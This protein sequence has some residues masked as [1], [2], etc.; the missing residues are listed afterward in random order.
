MMSVAQFTRYVVEPKKKQAVSVKPPFLR[1]DLS[2]RQITVKISD[3]GIQA[4]LNRSKV[5]ESPSS[6][7]EG[8]GLSII[9]LGMSLSLTNLFEM[10]QK[11]EFVS[12][13]CTSCSESNAG[14][15]TAALDPVTG[16]SSMESL[17]WKSCL[18]FAVVNFCPKSCHL[19][20]F[21]LILM[22]PCTTRPGQ[23]FYFRERSEPPGCRKACGQG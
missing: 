19:L 2:E 18:F 15:V 17:F 23:L 11:L 6:A 5:R 22:N 20:V 1:P 10:V 8:Q 7:F 14:S 3:N 13:S 9:K 21:K 12:L 4:N 16:S